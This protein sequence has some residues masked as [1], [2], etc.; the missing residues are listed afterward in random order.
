MWEVF[1]SP[2]VQD[3]LDKQDSNI[4]ERIRKGLK[5][6]EI[7]DPF[8]YIEHLESHD[9][10]KYRIGHYRALIEIDFENKL[11]KVQ[12]LDHRKKIYKRKH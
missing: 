5:K 7:E 2:D 11:L 3:F 9:Y 4:A 12:I 8:H 10:Y 1:L 6:L